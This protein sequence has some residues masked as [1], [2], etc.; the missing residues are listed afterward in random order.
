MRITSPELQ[1]MA[2]AL[3]LSHDTDGNHVINKPDI[4]RLLW[5]IVVFRLIANFFNMICLT[6][7]FLYKIVII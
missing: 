7:P 2:V 1:Y 4:L 5:D 3:S 6:L